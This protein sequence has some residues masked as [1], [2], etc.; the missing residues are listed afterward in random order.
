M[1]AAQKMVVVAVVVVEPTDDEW[2]RERVSEETLFTNNEKKETF[3]VARNRQD[4]HVDKG[5]CAPEGGGRAGE[6][7]APRG[8]DDDKRENENRAPAAQA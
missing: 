5:A 4:Q 2:D 8:G 7:T 1:A 3:F 6:H